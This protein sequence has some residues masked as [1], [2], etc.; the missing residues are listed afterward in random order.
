MERQKRGGSEAWMVIRVAYLLLSVILVGA[1]GWDATETRGQEA[2]PSLQ[3]GTITGVILDKRT[4]DPIADAGVE[5]VG[6]GKSTRTGLDGRQVVK[7]GPGPPAVRGCAAGMQGLRLQGVLVKT[8]Q[9]STADA[10]LESSGAA[11]LVV[12]VVAPA[13]KATEEAQIL[14]R[15]TAPTVSETISAETMRKAGGSDAAAVVRRAPG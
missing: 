15:K 14:K 10:A 12:E 6:Q 5:V 9:T 8:G 13:K 7:I 4:G 11:G 3:P 1:S 2:Q